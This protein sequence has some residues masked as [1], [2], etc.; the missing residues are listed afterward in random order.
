MTRW[1]LTALLAVGLT[2]Y[3]VA[4]DE[5]AEAQGPVIGKPAP[6]FRLND[7]HGRAVRLSDYGKGHWTVVAFYPKSDTPG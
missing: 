7:Q 4:G 6:D 3:A 2:A 5:E 1:I